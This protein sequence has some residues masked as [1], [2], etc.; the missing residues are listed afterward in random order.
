MFVKVAV[1]RPL[2]TFFDYGYDAEELGPIS[3]GDWVR[4]PFG[5][6]KLNACVMEISNETP[7]LPKGVGIKSVAE[8]LSVEF[9]LP[10][11]IVKLCRFGS[12][13][14]QYPIGEAMFVAAPPKMEKLLGTRQESGSE[15]QLVSKQKRERQLTAEQRKVLEGIQSAI[16][17]RPDSAFLLE[18][19][20]GSGKTEVYIELARSILHSGKSVLILVPEI[21]LTAQLRERFQS[22]LP[23][24]VVLWHSALSDGLRQNQWRKVKNGEIRVVVGA[25]SALF[26]PFRELGLIVVDEEHDATYKQEERFRYQARDLALFRAKQAGIP[27]VLGSATP[28][29]ESIHRVREGRVIHLKLESRFSGS[30]LPVIHPVSMIE[31]PPVGAGTVKTPLAETTIRAMQETIDRGEQVMIFL[32]RRGYSQFLLCQGCG[33][34]G[35]CDQCSISLTH[36]RK[37]NEL[38]CHVCGTKTKV[39]ETCGECGGTELFGMGSGTESL[40]EDLSMVLTGAKTLRLDRD[41]ITSQKRLEETLAEFRNLQANILIGTQMLVKGHDFPKV[42]CVVVASVDSLLKWPDFRAS[43]RALQTLIQVSGRA[44][45]A[46]LPGR[47]FLQGYDLD[48]PVIKILRGEG[49]LSEFVTDELEMRKMLHYPPDSRLVRYRFEHEQEGRCKEF[50][51]R[52]GSLVRGE[53]GEELADRVLGPSEALLFRAQNRYRYDLYFKSPTLDLLFRVS[54]S[55]R[56]VSA[57]AGVNLVVDVDPYH[58]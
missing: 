13:Y 14:Y 7:A 11:D 29:L 26:A 10:E 38:K 19:V 2:E 30:A 34:V 21:S 24:K 49:S 18:G 5:R 28:S 44:G 25:R 3:V 9:R 50:A 54:R 27:I 8:R 56:R 33:W 42:T 40:E 53:L 4:V 45:R 48:H 16:Q 20:T 37:R 36:Y 6:S 52:V 12:E 58:S 47:V 22:S 31:E 39:P 46:G 15:E 41:Q 43:E 57:E 35:K 23:E 1:P 51:S 17:D 32:N 55:V